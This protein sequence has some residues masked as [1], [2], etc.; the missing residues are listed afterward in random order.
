M[1]SEYNTP[2][3]QSNLEPNQPE[4]RSAGY[5]DFLNTQPQVITTPD[6]TRVVYD[7]ANVK[8]RPDLEW[9]MVEIRDVRGGLNK[10]YGDYDTDWDR[11]SSSTLD[12]RFSRTLCLPQ[13]L[14]TAASPDPTG[15]LSGLHQSFIYSQQYWA[16]GSGNDVSLFTETSTT[17]PTPSAI[18][19]AGSAGR[20]G[21]VILSL[22]NIVIG[23]ATAAE[24]LL[25]GR[26]GTTPMLM[27]ASTGTISGTAFDAALTNCYG[28]IQTPLNDRTTVFYANNGFYT[29]KATDAINTTPTLAT[30]NQPNGGYALHLVPFRLGNGPERCYWGMPFENTANGVLLFGTEKLHRVVS[31]NIEGTD[32]QGLDFGF[33]GVLKAVAIPAYGIIAGHDGERMVLHRGD[34]IEN[35]RLFEDREPDSDREYRLRNMWVNGPEMVYEVNHRASASGTGNTERWLEAYHLETGAVHQISAVETLSSTGNFGVLSPCSAPLS[36]NTL[37]AMTYADGSWRWQIQVPWGQNPYILLRQTSGAQSGTGNATE[38]SGTWV[39][40]NWELPGLE[41]LPKVISRITFLGDVDAGGTTATAAN[42]TMQAGNMGRAVTAYTGMPNTPQVF[43]ISPQDQSPFFQLQ[44]TITAARTT[45]STRFNLNC[46]PI[47]IEGFAW[48]D[49]YAE[50]ALIPDASVFSSVA[51][52]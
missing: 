26:A 14:A 41:G 17:D 32:V 18:T 33:K 42:V 28:A 36:K 49:L 34:A 11:A 51:G 19:G 43:D 12:T 39:S 20:P 46:L 37:A 35:L 10:T 45:N 16:L 1:T 47:R 24:A 50:T 3:Y 15:N 48:R 40:A 21:A 4:I 52:R 7:R 25:I 8:G 22:A 9:W 13:Q 5:Y 31:T 44:A 29:L 30:G 38:A 27:T 6:G 23:G 2:D